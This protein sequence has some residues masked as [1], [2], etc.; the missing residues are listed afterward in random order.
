M[1][2]SWLL[3]Y[4]FPFFRKVTFS[5]IDHIPKCPGKKLCLLLFRDSS[6]NIRKQCWHIS[7]CSSPFSGAFWVHATDTDVM[8]SQV[9]DKALLASYVPGYV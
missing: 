6:H 4:N 7:K 8:G 9:S 1:V 5:A 2:T 3:D